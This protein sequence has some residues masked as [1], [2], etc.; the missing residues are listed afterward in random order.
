MR[1]RGASSHTC[2]SQLRCARGS[3]RRLRLLFL[4][5]LHVHPDHGRRL[6]GQL[7]QHVIR[8]SGDGVVLKHAVGQ[9]CGEARLRQLASARVPRLYARALRDWHACT[10]RF[11]SEALDTRP[12]VNDSSGARQELRQRLRLARGRQKAFQLRK[13]IFLVATWEREHT[14]AVRRQSAANGARTRAPREMPCVLRLRL[15]TAA[16]A[17]IALVLTRS[18]KRTRFCSLRTCDAAG[19]T[20]ASAPPPVV[21]DSCLRLSFE[22]RASMRARRFAIEES[23]RSGCTSWWRAA[24]TRAA[25]K[26][27]GWCCA[28]ARRLPNAAADSAARNSDA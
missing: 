22:T 14:F 7:R 23:R 11:S 25:R 12:L 9:N 21:V 18:K 20:A 5:A 16:F 17:A 13:R 28:N 2:V 3:F 8:H 26:L 10:H 24:C 4:S 6:R 1:E 19:A 15:N 27:A